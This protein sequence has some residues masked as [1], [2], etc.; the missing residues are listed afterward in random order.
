MNLSQ[1]GTLSFYSLD[2]FNKFAG[3][4][5]FFAFSTSSIEK[6][7]FPNQSSIWILCS[8][9]RTNLANTSLLMTQATWKHG[10]HS[11]KQIIRMWP[12]IAMLGS[13]DLP[14]QF[15]IAWPTNANLVTYHFQSQMAW[16]TNANPGTWTYHSQPPITS[17]YSRNIWKARMHKTDPSKICN[18]QT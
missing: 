10:H 1:F 7:P 2:G 13:H 5:Y 8:K 12:T 15:Q 18:D 3:G 11:R 17:P 9:V 14:F 16:P 4:M 6:F